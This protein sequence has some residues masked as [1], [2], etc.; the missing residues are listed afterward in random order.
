MQ[1]I[2]GLN[3]A[4]EVLGTT[5]KPQGI[6]GHS[7]AQNALWLPGSAGPVPPPP[8]LHPDPQLENC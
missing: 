4:N 1:G 8:K 2:L 3:A 6:L 5:Q 7:M